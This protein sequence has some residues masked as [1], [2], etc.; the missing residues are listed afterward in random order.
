M[1]GTQFFRG[2]PIAITEKGKGQ[3]LVKTY[4]VGQPEDGFVV[5]TK[6]GKGRILALGT[7]LWWHW[8]TQNQAGG[9]D[10]VKLL[11]WLLVSK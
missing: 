11:E 7:S 2:S 6:V 5:M 10:N 1:I 9:T 4:G 8:I 3:V